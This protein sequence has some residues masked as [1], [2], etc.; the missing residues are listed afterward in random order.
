[1][2]TALA[3]RSCGI[4]GIHSSRG[5]AEN[6]NA[7]IPLSVVVGSVVYLTFGSVERNDQYAGLSALGPSW[8]P[9][10]MLSGVCKARTADTN[11]LTSSPECRS[12]RSVKSP[13]HQ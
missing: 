3:V 8:F 4:R 7:S 9:I 13:R 10:R 6:G 11:L 12:F 1:M 2:N 5:L